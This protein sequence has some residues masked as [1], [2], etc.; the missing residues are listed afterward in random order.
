MIIETSHLDRFWKILRRTRK[1]RNDIKDDGRG[2][3]SACFYLRSLNISLAIIPGR[4]RT[5]PGATQQAAPAP[6][7]KI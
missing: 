4:A 6:K 7:L 1:G 5:R 2:R 3:R